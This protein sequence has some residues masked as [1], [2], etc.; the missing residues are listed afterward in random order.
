MKTNPSLPPPV[1]R[2]KNIVISGTNFWNPGDDFVRD[3]VIRIL[4]E[5]FRDE[6]LNFL[7]YN[8]NADF[9]P[10]SKFAGIGNYLAKGDLEKYRDY[11][12]AVF[13]AGLSAGDEIKDLYRWIVANGLEEKV[14]LV[15]AGYE[16]DYVARHIGQEP[17]AT[18]F[19][20][21]RLVT[22]RT[23]KTPDFIQAA[24]IPYHHIN[25]PAILSVPAVKPVAAGRRVERLGFSIQLPHGDGLP[26]HS[27]GRRQY[28]LAVSVLRQLARG[29][30]VEVVAHHKTEYFHFLRLLGSENIPVLFSSF[31]QDLHQIYPRYDLV[32]TTR[33]HSS[34]FANGH[35]IPGIIINDTDRHTHTLDGF[36]HSAWVGNRAS[37]DEAFAHWNQSDLAAVAREAATFKSKLLAH[38]VQVLRPMMV[39]PIARSTGAEGIPT[40]IPLHPSAMSEGFPAALLAGLHQ[41]DN[42]RCVLNIISHLEKDY[43]LERNLIRY[44][45]T[46]AWFDAATLL[47][48][49]ARNLKPGNYLE[50]GVRRGRSM[51]QVLVESPETQAFGFDLWIPGY[52][53]LPEQ[54]IHTAN[55]GPEFVLGELAKLGISKL[56]KLVR[57]DS[58]AT[59]PVFFQDPANPQSF[60]LIL[61]DGDHTT[62]GARADLELAFAHLA[63][64]G[65]LIFDDI[66]N[67]AHPELRGLWD[68]FIQRY[69]DYLFINDHA[70]AGTGAAFRPPFNKVAAALKRA[71]GQPDPSANSLSCPAE[72]TELPVH[73]FT[74]VLNG[75]PFIQHHLAQMRQLPFRWHWHIVEGVAALNHDTGWSKVTGGKI[76]A[77]LHRNGLSKDGTTEYLDALQKEFPEDV[78]I[79]RPPPGKLWDGKRQM[80]NA[81]LANLS[82]ECLLWQLDVDEL[83]TAAQIIQTRSLFLAQPDKTAA[84][85][86]CHYFVGPELVV[87]SHNTYGNYACEWLRVWRYQ[88]G[89]RWQAHEPPRLCRGND[90]VGRLHPIR[91]PETQSH[92]LVFQHYAYATEAQLRFKE[93]YYGYPGAVAQ[94]QS[95]QRATKYPLRLAHYFKWVKDEA[96]VNTIS[97]QGLKR[98][99]P[100]EWFA[101]APFS[102]GRLLDGAQR[103][104][105]VR[106]D[107]IGDVVLASAMLE[108]IRK[109]YPQAKLAV[110]CQQRVASLFTACPFVDSII[111]YDR[112]KMLASG[113]ERQQIMDEIAAFNPEVILNSVRSRDRLSDE[114]TLAF[115]KARHIAI[116]TDLDN[117][118]AADRDAFRRRY[119]Q[120][121]P[122]PDAPQ[123]ELERHAAFLRGLG[124]EASNLQPVVWTSPE[125]DALAEAYFQSEKL[126]PKQTL[127][128][129]PFAQYGMK[130]YPAFAAALKEFAGWNILLL[131]GAESRK[132]CEQLALQL[133]GN[134]LNLAG[135]TTLREMAAL[136]RRCKILVGSDSCAVHIACA[137]GVPNVVVLGG[138]HFG[139]F[140][141]YSP[142]T[143]AAVL[144]LDCFGCNWRCP[145]DRTRCIANLA[146]EV[147]S[148]AI[149]AALQGPRLKPVI[150]AQTS[151]GAALPPALAARV[152]PGAVDFIAV[153]GQSLSPLRALNAGEQV[154]SIEQL[155]HLLDQGGVETRKLSQQLRI[156]AWQYQGWENYQSER[157]GAAEAEAAVLIAQLAP[158]FLPQLAP[159]SELDGRTALA[160]GLA[161][162]IQQDWQSAWA[163]YSHALM[164]P[165]KGILGFRLAVRLARIAAQR[166]DL[167]TSDSLKTQIIPKLRATLPAG[168]NPDVEEKAVLDWPVPPLAPAPA[169]PKAPSAAKAPAAPLVTAIVSTFKSERFIRGCLEDLEAQTMADR[170]EI[171]VVDSHSPQN[172][173]AVVE[174]FQQRYANI[175]YIRTEDRETVYGAWNR[176]ARAA[177]GKYLTN[178]NTDDRHRPD[179]L[180][181]LARTLEENPEVSLAYAD[182]LITPNENETYYTA[183]PEGVYNWLD[184]S[185]QALWSLGCFAGPQPMWRREVHAEHGYFDAEMISA[186]D[187]EFWL[188]L[189][190]NRRFLHVRATLG[191]YLKSPTSVE[192]ANREVGAREVELARQRYRDSI[193]AGKPPFRPKLPEPTV[194]VEIMLGG[195]SPP[196]LA[197]AAAPKSVPSVARLGQLDEARELFAQKVWAAAWAATLTA[198]GKRP[199]HPEAYLLLAEI[200]LAVGA[201]KAAKQC[202]RHA[203]DL[204]PGWSAVK[205]FLCRPL[206]GEA[207]PE[208]LVL[209]KTAA[210]RLSVCLIVKNEEKFL[211]Q[212]LKSV[213]GF[214]SQLI[215]VDTG[216]TDRTVEIAR[217]FGA[218]IH[219]FAWCDDF[220]AARNA[221]L[222]HAAGDWVLMLDADEE[223]PA[224]QHARLLADMKNANT[225]AYR[226][227][228]VNA[229]QEIEGRSFVPRLFRN[230]P[231]ACFTGRIHE[232]VFSSLLPNAKTWGLKTALG[233]AEIVHHGF[234]VEL[235]RERNKVQRNLRL[236]RAALEEDPAN[237][238]LLM[239]LGLE[240]VR[241]DELAAGIEK[242]R[243]AYDRMS[244][245]PAAEVA[246]EIR[247]AFLTQFTFAKMRAALPIEKPELREASQAQS[248]S[249][250][251]RVRAYEE[252][253]QILTSPLALHGGL[254]A[255]L[256]FALGRAYFELKR[257]SEAADEMRQCLAKRRQPCLTPI[258][259]DVLTAA[260]HHC[261]ALCLVELDDL[262]GAEAAF[263]AAGAET[264]RTHGAVS[265]A[266]P[267]VATVE[268]LAGAENKLL[269]AQSAAPQARSAVARLGQLNEA[270]E[271]FGRGNFAAAWAAALTASGKRPFHPEAYLLLAEIALAVGAGKT[272]KQCA[273]RAR[274][275]AP[276]WSAVKQFLCRPLKGEAKPEWLVLP[277]T[278]GHPLS[279]CLIA[280]NE[281]KFLAQCLKSVR[282][283]ATQLIVVDTGS[284]DRTVEIAREFGAEIYFFAWCDDFAAARNAALEHATGDW[285]LMLDADEELLGAQHAKLRADMKNASTIAFR[286]PLVNAGQEIEGRSFVP[287]LFRNAP[288]ACFTGRIHEQVFSSLLGNAKTW[289]LKTAL[290]SA[291]LRHHGYTKDLVQDRNKVERNLKL[292]RAAIEENPADV[293]LQMNLGLE[294]VR[295]DDL[296]AGVVKYR[297]AYD[298]MSAQRPDELV[299]ELREVLLTQFTSQLYKIHAHE[300]VVHVLQSRLAQ[301][302]GLTASLHFALGLAHF[303]LKQFSEAANQMRQCLAKRKQPGL[304]PINTDI[305]T[306]APS[307]CLALCLARQ[308][309]QSAAE[310]AFVAALTETGHVEAAKLD[311]A[312]FLL[313]GNRH[314]DA[315][316]QLNGLVAADSRHLAAWRLGGEIALGRPEFLEF[317]LDWT[318]EAAKALPEN[319]VIAAQRAE[320]LM[321]NR[322]ASEALPLWE[323]IWRSEHEPRTLAALI[324]CEM[325]TDQP[326]HA[327]NAGEDERATSLAFVEWYQKL[328][329]ARAKPLL[330]EINA[331]LEPLSR[332]LPAA[333]DMLQAALAEAA[334]P[335][336]VG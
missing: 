223:L 51:A 228:L 201:G 94:W 158:Q 119:E 185:A 3:G 118:S 63:P 200:A 6:P 295:S 197:Q 336:A 217:E 230:A 45:D 269:P 78:T 181:I 70:A 215:V 129:F 173:R 193:M 93:T 176:G 80:V 276:G 85:F 109:K 169:G 164:R 91:Q 148:A 327:P 147:V 224:A 73:F 5:V 332:T 142:L 290:G 71:I 178:A 92:G 87:T 27:C 41:P 43:W 231:G 232:Q 248:I 208:W 190:Q 161:G 49:I 163:C 130:D 47:N 284:T 96:I 246:P 275:L 273:Q 211:A 210:H 307:H 239:N 54:G 265:E 272:A 31:Y 28:E 236:L 106:T 72:E 301:H 219:F 107:S 205:Q 86:Y 132:R 115:A 221:A 319:P 251:N 270:R 159:L 30:A 21:A 260:P 318:A 155:I 8:F 40:S 242:Y 19:R 20:K 324:L 102:S 29:Y 292:L 240:L 46:S 12:D 77:E 280:K 316:H 245:Q 259:T 168:S 14:Y 69:P 177:R 331:R 172:E 66:C 263:V 152:A 165:S 90:D 136:I 277:K 288:G 138:G 166:G 202:A 326:A 83:W 188:R 323:K 44:Q 218:E 317:A 287:R 141:P 308:G 286:L 95:L 18:I 82:K 320:A 264:A 48:W 64:G 329:G 199:C 253:V 278:V 37:F 52:G 9:F 171:I 100:S 122:S 315:L 212:C 247:E 279:V 167:A 123:T 256:H 257:F 105:F 312:Q 113:E 101:S 38:Y 335:L 184:F 50:I 182:C 298:L 57:G 220:A 328:I 53:S 98:L 59:L 229:G 56:P 144:P 124:I 110:L 23:A 226:L 65:I 16:N 151:T 268:T 198:I 120:L 244:A 183:N 330:D 321:L 255:S 143:T 192:H 17:E 325:A 58:H 89:D 209:P 81:P 258:N 285:V 36:P 309:D 213:R 170:L 137:V 114:L 283:L 249:Q 322:H 306:A 33:L 254:T 227:P 187:Y 154:R 216:S 262:P 214:A 99:A 175:V 186:G 62:E 333:A 60:D 67:T 304:T 266:A 296:P 42:K 311:Y 206:K 1:V 146:P 34:L 194:K 4:R 2:T 294:L 196:T 39:G 282:G 32:I 125:D 88:P 195:G 299:P 225:I 84:L 191:L 10:Q 241:A 13:I 104:L 162:E 303:E 7:F 74:I 11:L 174:E 135:R 252:V 68:Q 111:C 291:E 55:P 75:Q 234:S 238:N 145:Y 22:G 35:G 310:K 117:I 204:A 24:G 15:G 79:Y 128:L 97:S 189:A 160:L 300:E 281:E 139:R 267:P 127:A 156:I 250:L 261:L 179:A 157:A 313:N 334:A 112:D 233:T 121:I 203:R 314:L 297:H 180:E 131:G 103:I 116:E 133:S 153:A 140:M 61:V 243:E 150:V 126:E 207:K 305:L 274:D 76:P 271:L 289:G 25:C 237:V 149:A 134:V 293:N 235:V 26:N 108:P 222:E 302:G